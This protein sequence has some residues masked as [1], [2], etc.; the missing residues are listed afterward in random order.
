[1]TEADL[2]AIRM[3]T[4]PS[5]GPAHWVGSLLCR[6]RGHPWRQTLRGI[7]EH[8]L[9]YGRQCPRCWAEE[10]CPCL[11]CHK[12]RAALAAPEEGDERQLP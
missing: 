1:M 5:E 4:W 11:G 12:L 3:R 10:D 9:I 2:E 8:Q 7:Q 6:L